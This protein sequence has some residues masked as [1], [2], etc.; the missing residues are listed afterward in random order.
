MKDISI[1]NIKRHLAVL[2]QDIGVRLAGSTGERQA[3]D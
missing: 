1:E 2:T 3:A